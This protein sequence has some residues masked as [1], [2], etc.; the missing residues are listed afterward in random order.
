MLGCTGLRHGAIPYNVISE[1][2]SHPLLRQLLYQCSFVSLPLF[3]GYRC[4]WHS[5]IQSYWF[6]SV[7][8]RASAELQSGDYQSRQQDQLVATVGMDRKPVYFLSPCC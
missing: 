2:Q 1:S 5:S 4:F 7:L 6:P 3:L 8:K